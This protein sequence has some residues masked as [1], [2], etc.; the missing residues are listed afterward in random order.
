MKVTIYTDGGADP[1]PGI[2]GWA[3]ILRSGAHERVLTGNDPN[4]TNNRMELQAAIAAL[5]ALNRPC[6]V[7]FYTDSEY[8]RR[9]ITEWIANWEARG[10]L[11]KGG[12][13]V[14]NKALWQALW[15][16]TQRHTI[17]WH[18]VRGH[19]GDP[20][21]ERVDV[22]AREARLAITPAVVLPADTPRLFVRAACRGNPGPGGWGVVLERNVS[23]PGRVETT[24]SSGWEEETTNNRMEL[25]GVI[26]GLRLLGPGRE[27]TAGQGVQ[28]FT[29]SDYVFQG[30]TKWI[31][32][33]RRR[34]WTKKDGQPV[35]NADLWQRLDQLAGQYQVHWVNAKG[36][37]P[38]E[39]ARA[40][41]EA[42]QLAAA[43]AQ[44][45]V[46]DKLDRGGA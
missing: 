8:V 13:Q 35:A 27:L 20:L 16:Q 7:T 2:G 24:Q 10:W 40:L 28:L 25:V 30:A 43:A 26:E 19:A 12:K 33:W 21:N 29:A 4:T 22:L 14:P 36:E 45:A 9:G 42:G 6:E 37:Q 44:A 23:T 15:R 18:W 1:N 32:G 3:A 34:Q 41:A 39:L 38:A 17:E 11:H 5:E 46:D 31:H